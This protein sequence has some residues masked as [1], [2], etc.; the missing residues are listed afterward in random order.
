MD[1]RIEFGTGGFRGVIGETFNKENVQIIAQAIADLIIAENSLQPVVIGFDYRF[2]SDQAAKW[3]CEVLCANR[4]SCLLSKEPTPTPSVMYMTKKL[5]NDYGIMITA[6]HNP[7]YFNG[8]KVFQKDG[9]DADIELTKRIEKK[10]KEQKCVK[11]IEFT[12]AKKT[13]YVRTISFLR[14]YI[15]S[16]KSWISNK[17]VGSDISVLFDNLHGV[18]A[19][20]L[21]ALAK[22][23]KLNNFE[24]ISKKQDAFFGGMLPNPTKENML[25]DRKYLKKKKYDCILGI[26][27]DGDRLGVLDEQGN[28][29]D[30]NEILSCLYY[31]LVQYRGLKGDSVKNCA[32]S[33]LLNKVTEKLG[34]K[35]HEVDV[36]FKNISGKMREI[37]ALLGGESSGGL[38]VRNYLYGKDSTFASALFLEMCIVMNKPVS[39]IVKEVRDFANF[40]HCDIEDTISY[41]DETAVLTFLTNEKLDLPDNVIKK[42]QYGRNI[43]YIFDNDCWVL[44]RR[45]GTEP[46]L[47]IF[48]EMESEEKANKYLQ[49]L[50]D[51]I[52]KADIESE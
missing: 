3:I 21:S 49:L 15:F 28:Y 52:A 46:V 45:S 16:I 2:L 31:Y 13:G 14:D 4:I 17:V 47:R 40:Y 20:S 37:D 5:G 33:N 42:E 11:S 6:S 44:L 30:S 29:V 50:N 32:T 26:D 34:Y 25:L 48:I 23:L 12:N 10:I 1:K 19:K 41:H 8:V 35:C 27:S 9:M 51:Y 43:K 39:Q 7:Y 18:G 38:T 22:E 24:T 36:G